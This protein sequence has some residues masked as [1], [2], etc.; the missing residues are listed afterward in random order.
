M[1]ISAFWAQVL[2]LYAV[3]TSLAFLFHQNRYRKIVS[4]FLDNPALVVLSGCFSLLVGLWIVVSH[5][6]WWGN[7]RILITLIGWFAV[8]KGVV[9][10]F[11]PEGFAKIAKHFVEGVSY[12]VT[13]WIWLLIGLY[14]LWMVWM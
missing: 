14:L 8:L 6:M 7:W 4:D 1:C 10:L 12:V 3:L 2:G 11:F 5:N 13:F 9:R